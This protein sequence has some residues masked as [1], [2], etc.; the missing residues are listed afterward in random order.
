MTVTVRYGRSEYYRPLS[1][2]AI[3]KPYIPVRLQFGG[4]HVDTIG[5]IDS[6]ADGSIFNA[7][8]ALALG[9]VL[10]PS[11]TVELGGLGGTIRGW[12][13]NVYI[14]TFGK[15]FPANVAFAAQWPAAHG[16]LG[17]EDFFAAYR[18]GFD[19]STNEFH[20]QPVS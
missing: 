20:L 10:D 12:K 4:R 3:A 14:S 18:V 6:G 13:L 9:F 19:Q 17:R 8:F 2:G 7:D 11:R 5:L 1:P 15:R 16:L